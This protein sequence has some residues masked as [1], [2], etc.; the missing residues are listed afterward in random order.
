MRDTKEPYTEN[1]TDKKISETLAAR[2]ERAGTILPKERD[3]SG[4]DAAAGG[5]A[6]YAERDHEDLGEHY[7]RHVEAMTAEGLHS[8]SAIAAELAYRDRRIHE[9]RS[10]AQRVSGTCLG[11]AMSGSN[12]PDPDKALMEL[13]EEGQR[14][15]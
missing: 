7:Y 5:S 6:Q 4:V 14:L 2:R 13:F 12:H 3:V 11:L 1:E 10:F 15:G 9:L 8:K